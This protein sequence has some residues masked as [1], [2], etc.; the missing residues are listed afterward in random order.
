MSEPLHWKDWLAQYTI[1][2]LDAWLTCDT[3][4]CD[5]PDEHA[6]HTKHD[7]RRAGWPT[8]QALAI[9]H[10]PERCKVCGGIGWIANPDP[11]YPDE[12]IDV[13]CPNCIDQARAGQ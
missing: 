3:E 13:R 2:E 7:N 11:L 6:G 12:L 1:A 9:L 10:G 4:G 5:T 8:D